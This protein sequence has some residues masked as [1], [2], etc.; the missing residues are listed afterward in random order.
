MAKDLIKTN[1]VQEPKISAAKLAAY[2]DGDASKRNK[3]L[4]E[5]KFPDE[6][7][8][9]VYTKLYPV[10]SRFIKG[11][12]N[13]EILENELSKLSH[14]VP[15][16]EFEKTNNKTLQTAIEHLIDTDFSLIQRYSSVPVPYKR[17]TIKISGVS[18]SYIPVGMLEGT[19]KSKKY[20]GLIALNP[21]KSGSLK[22]DAAK[23]FAV[24]SKLFADQF[25]F[26]DG[27][28]STKMC[29]SIDV[30]SKSVIE[31]PKSHV[32]IEKN[33]RISCDEIKKIWPN[34]VNI[35]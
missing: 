10:V 7:K 25:D 11:N 31:C 9:A 8:N 17:R 13:I 33:I 14:I 29:F 27:E 5:H 34:V 15:V 3:I 12:C 30:Y 28:V 4:R 6:Y 2:L 19:F 21:S 20:F 24:L 18:V 1:Q 32:R 23:P 35:S 16:S 26:E 22:G